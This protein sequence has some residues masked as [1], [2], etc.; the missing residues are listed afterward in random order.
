MMV[1]YVRD[2]VC[3]V[4]RAELQ[5]RIREIASDGIKSKEKSQDEDLN[6]GNA[7]YPD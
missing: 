4:P 5:W 7:D 6:S 2:G 1:Y 3:A